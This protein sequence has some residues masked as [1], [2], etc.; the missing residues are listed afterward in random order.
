[1]SL[2]SY[3]AAPPRVPRRGNIES[4]ADSASAFWKIL[5]EWILPPKLLKTVDLHQ[6]EETAL[7]RWGS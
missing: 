3:Q 7:N 5:L 4:L 2:T 1:M 6:A